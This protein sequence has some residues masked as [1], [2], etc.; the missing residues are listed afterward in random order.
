M[1]FLLKYSKF[2]GII[3]SIIAALSDGKISRE[4]AVKLFTEVIDLIIGLRKK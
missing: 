4:E 2:F 1:F 3:R